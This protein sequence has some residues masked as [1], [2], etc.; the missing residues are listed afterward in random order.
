MS[1]R[2]NDQPKMDWSDA[3]P[4]PSFLGAGLQVGS[5]RLLALYFD[6]VHDYRFNTQS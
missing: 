3:E 1:L 6:V 5:G 4:P 2:V